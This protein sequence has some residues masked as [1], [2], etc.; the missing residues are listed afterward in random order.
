MT[1]NQ[2]FTS[3]LGKK[4][5]MALTGLFL[6]SFLIVHVG[7]NSCIFVNDGGETFNT[8]AHFM[9]HNWVVRIL[10]IGLF[11]GL[12][13]HIVQGLMLWA[14]NN[15]ARP[16]K[17]EVKDSS[18]NSTWYSR[19]MGLLGTLLLFFLIIHL[20]HFWVETKQDLY[21]GEDNENSY[22][23]II[24]VFHVWYWALAYVLGVISLFWHLFHGFQS[25]FQSLGVNHKKYTPIIKTLGYGYSIIVCILF[26]LMPI[27]VFLD[28]IQ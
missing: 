12:I 1:W 18:K 9:S 16:V 23:S 26:A 17:Y 21:F 25:A 24:A 13:L 4:Y 15:A 7:V 22:A 20:S 6:V 3:S 8:A 27:L 5:V 14:Q 11:A 28:V 2:F 19:S 10:E